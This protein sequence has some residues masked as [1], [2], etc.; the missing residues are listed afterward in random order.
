MFKI[1]AAMT[2]IPTGWNNHFYA[3]E[4]DSLVPLSIEKLERIRAQQLKDWSKQ[5]IRNGTIQH[6][7]KE[8]VLLARRNYKDK[9]KKPHIIT[10]IDN[11][12]DEEF[13]ADEYAFELDETYKQHILSY[14]HKTIKSISD[15][16]RELHLRKRIEK[17]KGITP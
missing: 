2:A 10:E 11:M 12:S 17:I 9:L 15:E 16:Q 5:V 4:G 8:A 3:R 1:P 13:S 6:L 7:D 14:L